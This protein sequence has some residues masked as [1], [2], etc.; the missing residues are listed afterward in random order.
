MF[1]DSVM[2]SICEYPRINKTDTTMHYYYLSD[3]K[4]SEFDFSKVGKSTYGRYIVL[5]YNGYTACRQLMWLGLS[6]MSVK[7]AE[8]DDD[9]KYIRRDVAL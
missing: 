7:Y 8:G 2:I 3:F 1:T 4:P 5:Y 9:V 6:D